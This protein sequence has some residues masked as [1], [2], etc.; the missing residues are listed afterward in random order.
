MIEETGEVDD[1]WEG[2][3]DD[4]LIGMGDGKATSTLRSKK[5]KR[6]IKKFT[7]TEE[8]EHMDH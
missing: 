1:T 6:S 7:G 8:N 3:G 4:E 2:T 5:P